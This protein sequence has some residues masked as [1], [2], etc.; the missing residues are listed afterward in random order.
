M[1]NGLRPDLV[2]VTGFPGTGPR[3]GMARRAPRGGDSTPGHKGAQKLPRQKGPRQVG[4]GEGKPAQGAPQAEKPQGTV[5]G[6]GG[7]RRRR[8]SPAPPWLEATPARPLPWP[9]PQA[10][11]PEPERRGPSLPGTRRAT[12]RTSRSLSFTRRTHPG[13]HRRLLNLHNQFPR[14]SLP[15]LPAARLQPQASAPGGRRQRAG[16]RG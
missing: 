8:P 14:K 5:V 4:G 13:R 11:S 2:T 1:K 16:Q 9:A 15:G 12:L 7:G 10:P 6:G 3:Q